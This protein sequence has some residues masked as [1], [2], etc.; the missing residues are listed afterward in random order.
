M[1]RHPVHWRSA[2]DVAVGI[3]CLLLATT[4]TFTGPPAAEATQWT[5]GHHRPLQRGCLDS[6]L[7]CPGKN[8]TCRVQ[9][10]RAND[11]RSRTCYCDTACLSTNDCCADMQLA[12]NISTSVIILTRINYYRIMGYASPEACPLANP[13]NV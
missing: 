13:L 10:L 12:C 1:F 4:A 5:G 7:C 3:V 6:R 11:R 2:L 9:G 8:S